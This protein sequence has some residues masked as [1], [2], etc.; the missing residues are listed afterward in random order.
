MAIAIAQLLL[1]LVLV[2]SPWLFG[3]VHGEAQAWFSAAVLAALVCQLVGRFSAGSARRALPV[4]ILPL[5]A[6]LGLGAF[7]LLPLDSRAAALLSPTGVELRSDLEARDTAA[8]SSLEEHFGIEPVTSQPISLYP[9]ST[10]HD[11]S[12]LILAAA[13]FYLGATLFQTPQAQLR[14]CAILAINGASVAFFG[15]VQHLTWNGKLYWRVPLTYHGQVFGP[16]V[17]RNNAAGYLN[18]CLAAAMGLTIW[19]LAGRGKTPHSPDGGIAPRRGPLL[20]R[21][22]Q[23][24][25]DFFARLNARQILAFSLAACIIAGILCSLSRGAWIA[26]LGAAAITWLVML[27]ARRRVLGLGVLG[28]VV[29]AGMALAVWVGMSQSVRS[30]FGILLDAK[31]GPLRHWED[32]AQTVPNFWRFG[33]GLGTYGH[34]Y[35]LYEHHVREL[36]FQHA[37]N[38]YL[39]ALVE[40]GVLGLGLVLTSI[41]LVSW[42]VWYVIRN[43]TDGRALAFGIAAVFAVSSQVLQA[44]FDFGFHIPA[45]ALTLALLG[46]AI[47]G[48][49]AERSAGRPSPSPLALPGFRWVPLALTLL[50]AAGCAWAFG[51][52]RAVAAV[53]RAMKNTRFEEKLGAASAEDLEGAIQEQAAALEQ[54]PDDAEA[55]SRMALLWMHLY[56]VRAFD[57]LRK[58]RVGALDD[59][60]LWTLTSPTLVHRRLHDF[61]REKSHA[62]LEMLRRQ[63]SIRET[64]HPAI[65]HFLLARRAC[66]LLPEVH[67]GL[68]ELC[69]LVV[70]PAGDGDHLDRARRLVPTHSGYLFQSGLLDF[71]AGRRDTAYQSWKQD[72]TLSE[73]RLS[74]VLRLVG[75]QVGD[76]ETVRK[77]LPD[78]PGLLVR[79]AKNAADEHANVRRT[80]AQR[81]LELLDEADL[82]EHE[83]H[84][85]RGSAFVLREQYPEA[86]DSFYWA[87]E[88]R[89][90]ETMR[91]YELALLLAQEGRIKEA[92][93]QAVLCARREPNN[94]RFEKLRLELSRQAPP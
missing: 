2:V 83:R 29:I 39:E 13:V 6:G 87:V 49:A 33:S 20:E 54:R 85:L 68:G 38:E 40:A 79:L 60:A 53:E 59:A 72:L 66:P 12:L 47:S 17:N 80:L 5:I 58:G 43:E 36:W 42:A 94:R 76:L 26:T 48:A 28:L 11:L 90:Q 35:G 70:D 18:L 69:G 73:R 50:F 21:V 51:Q 92:Y 57:E 63:K 77:L 52:L 30:R 22:R 41:A 10:R 62:R 64:L 75:G 16:F 15:I 3:G 4:A 46:G 88:A 56:R 86:I 27:A 34:V 9:A 44:F 8:G 25:V 65:E 71:Q 31:Y 61:A 1:I 19:L 81:A 23:S 91:R 82:P 32:A 45:N 7:Q 14:L 93:E 55:H 74:D 89:P 67:L 37:E 78:S 84:Y 24:V